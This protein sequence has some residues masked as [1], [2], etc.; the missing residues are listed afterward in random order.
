[1]TAE[2]TEL[3]LSACGN[4]ALLAYSTGHVDIFNVQSARFM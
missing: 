4:M 1:M 3:A 2:C